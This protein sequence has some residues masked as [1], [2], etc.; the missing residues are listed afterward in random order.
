MS[1]TRPK[2]TNVCEELVTYLSLA[3]E[4]LPELQNDVR[5]AEKEVENAKDRLSQ[6]NGQIVLAQRCKQMYEKEWAQSEAQVR[7]R[8]TALQ[9]AAGTLSEE[10]DGEARV[11]KRTKRV[12]LASDVDAQPA[13]EPHA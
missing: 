5:R 3:Q 2:P 12:R 6:L 9:E 4:K 11:S 13:D 1:G 10:S 7:A 8:I